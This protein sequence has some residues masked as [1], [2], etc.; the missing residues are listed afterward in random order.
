MQFPWS[1]GPVFLIQFKFCR[2]EILPNYGIDR[3]GNKHNLVS[4]SCL[5][6]V[7]HLKYNVLFI[8]V[9]LFFFDV[10]I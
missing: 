7:L 8:T 6:K 3:L 9:L 2:L 5:F 4:S 10:P 1:V